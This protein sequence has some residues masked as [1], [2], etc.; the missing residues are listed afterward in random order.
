MNQKMKCK[1]LNLRRNQ[2][3]NRRPFQKGQRRYAIVTDADTISFLR[4]PEQRS[5][6]F[7]GCFKRA[8]DCV[9]NFHPKKAT[10][11]IYWMFPIN[12]Q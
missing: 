12:R 7:C 6:V 4:F 10:S 3:S 1:E 2:D 9:L 8:E 11:L 5:A